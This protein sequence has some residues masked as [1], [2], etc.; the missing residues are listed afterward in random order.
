VIAEFC[1]REDELLDAL[2]RGFVNVD[3]EAHV[4]ACTSCSELRLVAGAL[5]N[6]RSQAI[7]EATVPSASSIWLRM[8]IRQRQEAQARARQS[9]LIGQAVTISVV[10]ALVISFFGLD[11]AWGVRDMIA[12]IR[13]TTP[14]FLL[15]ATWLL[16]TPIAGWVAI[17]QK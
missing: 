14:L 6:E 8:Q 12:S 16:I 2:G 9:L 11:L 17:R 10:F 1:Q 15:L 5:L 13:L 7:V 3:L 4:A